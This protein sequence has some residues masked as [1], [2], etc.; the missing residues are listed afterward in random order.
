[1]DVRTMMTKSLLLMTFLSVMAPCH[2]FSEETPPLG[3]AID[4]Y[5][6]SGKAMDAFHQALRTTEAGEGQTRMMFFGASH[7]ASDTYT[8][9]LRRLLQARFGDAG[10]GFVLPAK[11]WRYYR[12]RDVVIDGTLTW[13]ADWVGKTKGRMDGYF[14]LG[15]VADESPRV[16]VQFHTRKYACRAHKSMDTLT[17]NFKYMSLSMWAL[18]YRTVRSSNG[19]H[20]TIVSSPGTGKWWDPLL[21]E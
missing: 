7:V 12:H 2:A 19:R 4:L 18:K 1:M 17:P 16:K 14:G 13:W 5:D 9:R 20:I 21:I 6:P 8:G 11:P 15:G 10:H 3:I